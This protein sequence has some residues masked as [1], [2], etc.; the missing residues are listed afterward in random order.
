MCGSTKPGSS[1]ALKDI[2][3]GF[4]KPAALIACCTSS[5]EPVATMRPLAMPT[6]S[7]VWRPLL[8]RVWMGP[9]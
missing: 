8:A 3:S 5:R 4:L 2:S 1:V 6:A 9:P 7:T